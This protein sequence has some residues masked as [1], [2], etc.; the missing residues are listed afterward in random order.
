MLRLNND[1]RCASSFKLMNILTW[2]LWA[3]YYNSNQ[4]YSRM[5][6]IQYYHGQFMIICV[7]IMMKVVICKF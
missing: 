2:N 7:Q 4:K 6:K 1:M 3:N 5:V